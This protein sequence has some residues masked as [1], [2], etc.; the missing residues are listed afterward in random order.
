MTGSLASRAALAGLFAMAGAAAAQPADPAPLAA[1]LGRDRILLASAPAVDDPGILAQ[2]RM[3]IAMRAG[4]TERDLVLVEAIGDGDAARTIRQQFG[5][6]GGSFRT[7]LIG[8]DGGAK[9]RSD[10]PLG[11]GE[12][13]PLI[14]AMPMRQ[15]EMSRRP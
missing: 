8:K 9:L 1:R 12:V 14:D 4:A 10:R 6:E 5:I 13:F 11:S 2:R 7:V 15:N 3:F